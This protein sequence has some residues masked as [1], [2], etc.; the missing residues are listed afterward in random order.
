MSNNRKRICVNRH[1]H[2]E[3]S[4]SPSVVASLGNHPVHRQLLHEGPA[5]VRIVPVLGLRGAST[6]SLHSYAAEPVL[7]G[8]PC[9]AAH[10]GI[11]FGKVVL[12]RLRNTDLI[13]ESGTK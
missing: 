5:A 8:N 6:P 11:A 10:I 4:S 3:I 9:V 12:S 1:L 7:S 13:L 2:P